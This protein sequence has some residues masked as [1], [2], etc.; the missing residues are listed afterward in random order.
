MKIISSGNKKIMHPDI[1]FFCD[2]CGC[3]FIAEYGEY[4]SES[5]Q[6]DGESWS[7]KCPECGKNISTYN[8]MFCYYI[9]KEK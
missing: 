2:K 7:I 3:L 1:K 9:E 8:P 4:N 6:I 5:T